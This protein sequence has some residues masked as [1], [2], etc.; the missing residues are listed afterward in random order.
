MYAIKTFVYN[1]WQLLLKHL[2]FKTVETMDFRVIKQDFSRLKHLK[3]DS[4]ITNNL[5]YN[6]VI[7]C[8]FSKLY[9]IV[10]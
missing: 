6:T 10:I 8:A 3:E 2:L 5:S 4:I 1:V 7:I 9:N